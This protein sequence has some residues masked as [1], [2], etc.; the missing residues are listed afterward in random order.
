[1]LLYIMRVE[2]IGERIRKLRL[3]KGITQRELATRARLSK[4]YISQLEKGTTLP[5]L[6]NL[7]EILD[8]L[9]ISLSEFF[10]EKSPVKVVYSKKDKITLPT[11]DDGVRVELLIPQHL[12]KDFDMFLIT[13]EPKAKTKEGQPH[14]GEETGYVLSGTLT[15]VLGTREITA[16]KGESY[17][18]VPDRPHYMENRGTRQCVALHLVSPGNI[19]VF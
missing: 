15:I 12:D 13:L 19:N 18:L 5:S 17:F 4:G 10:S 2:E 16:R 6:L 14:R 1:M 9:G 8:I 11:S 3:E 7:K